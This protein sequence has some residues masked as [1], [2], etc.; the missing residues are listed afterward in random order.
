MLKIPEKNNKEIGELTVVEGKLDKERSAE[1][2]KVEEVLASLNQETEGLQENKDV[3]S[4]KLIEL[5]KIKDN[6][7]SKVIFC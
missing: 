2:L 3:L 7:Q 4:N 6:K 5:K 1:E